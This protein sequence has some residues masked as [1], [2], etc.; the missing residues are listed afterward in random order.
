MAEPAQDE[1][2]RS[3]G[4]RHPAVGCGCSVGVR[5]EWA[6]DGRPSW[7]VVEGTRLSATQCHL[8]VG[9]RFGRQGRGGGGVSS[10]LSLR[11]T[12]PAPLGMRPY[13]CPSPNGGSL[14]RPPPPPQARA[15]L[16][17]VPSEGVGSSAPGQCRTDLPAR[18]V[19][20][21]GR[22]WTG[23]WRSTTL[24]RKAR[25]SVSLTGRAH[26]HARAPQARRHSVAEK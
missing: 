7:G 8:R 15:S 1:M 10:T 2:A 14:C 11:A 23:T 18:G 25:P 24:V 22:G 20:M 5:G 6:K 16:P 13:P 19:P 26:T 9:G 21:P 17:F 4:T 3:G 12:E